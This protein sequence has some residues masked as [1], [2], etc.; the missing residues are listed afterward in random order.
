MEE[1]PYSPA[2][3]GDDHDLLREEGLTENVTEWI[4]PDYLGKQIC[5][6]AE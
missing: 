3:N 1:K 5:R 6:E 4:N 2:A